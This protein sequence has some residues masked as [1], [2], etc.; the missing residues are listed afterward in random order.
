MGDH[1]NVCQ[2]NLNNN[3]T[4]KRWMKRRWNDSVPCTLAVF[5]LPLSLFVYLCLVYLCVST[6]KLRV[7]NLCINLISCFATPSWFGRCLW[8]FNKR[9]PRTWIHCKCIRI[10]STETKYKR[11]IERTNPLTIRRRCKFYVDLCLSAIDE[12]N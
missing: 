4:I 12:L 3:T 11:T 2:V 8:L 6:K 10:N 1:R 9:E 7:G 5:S